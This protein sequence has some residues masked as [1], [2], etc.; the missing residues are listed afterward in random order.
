MMNVSRTFT[1][2]YLSSKSLDFAKVDILKEITD[3]TLKSLSKL[4][5]I[6]IT[7]KLITDSVI[8]DLTENHCPKLRNFR[9][10]CK[11]EFSQQISCQ[12]RS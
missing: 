10:Y 7:S 5:Y 12:N 11:N 6:C 1:C 4:D 3:S 8:C 2:I 9:I